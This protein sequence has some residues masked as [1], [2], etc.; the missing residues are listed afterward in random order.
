VI[1]LVFS[2]A[3]S[4]SPI[5]LEEV[6]A[7]SR[8]NLDALKAE[9]T[10]R[11]STA[12]VT[13]AKSF[14]FPQVQVG[15]QAQGFAAGPQRIYSTVP[16][17]GPN[18]SLTFDQQS[19]DV[20]GANRG[21][22]ALSLTVTQL[23]YDGGKWWNNIAQAGATE[24]ANEGFLEEQR[25]VSELEA[26]SR[27]YT[28]LNAQVALDVFDNSVRRSQTQVDRAQ[29]LFEAGRGPKRDAVDAEVNVGSDRIA[30][31]RQRQ[32][33]VAAQVA[34]LQWLGLPSK[35]VEAVDPGT[36][37]PKRKAAGA[38][39]LTVAMAEAMK[40]R[41]LLRALEAQVRSTR[42]AVDVAWA[43]YI[44][45][46]ALQGGYQRQSPTADPFFTDPTRQNVVWGG[47]NLNWNAFQGFQ[48]QGQVAQAREAVIQAELTRDRA[49]TDLEGDLRRS[50]EALS[51]NI[52][53]AEL[54][55]QNVKLAQ[56]SLTLAEDRFTAGAGSTL[57][58]RDAQVKLTAAQLAQ[59]QARVD[60]EVA[61]AGV[62]RVVGTDVEETQR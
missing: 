57:E 28:L 29:S 56:S 15:A 4:A 46:V 26:V 3:V 42:R 10:W 50:L 38:P 23:L 22:F 45:Q 36:F 14:I 53:V 54:A 48:T 49:G 58:V 60:V 21:N 11:Q 13:V 19:V 32:A 43:Q 59:A 17:L 40:S 16:K 33:I 8:Q 35:P 62:R 44:P 37:D 12:G 39:S 9:I 30:V 18:N 25:L 41:P 61:R 51:T 2:L 34:L 52:E 55:S 27:F 47:L 5:T 7:A 20:P 24:E 6:R 31:L 1:A